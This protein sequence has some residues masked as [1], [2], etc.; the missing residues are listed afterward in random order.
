MLSPLPR[1]TSVQELH[2]NED[3]SVENNGNTSIH[4]V[5]TNGNP[6]INTNS[7]SSNSILDA[8]SL[9][10]SFNPFNS[11]SLSMKFDNNNY[12][13]RRNNCNVLSWLVG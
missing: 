8:F 11:M 13:V 2:A 6:S 5:V 7:Q 12:L 10:S 9:H 4:N 1:L 3:K